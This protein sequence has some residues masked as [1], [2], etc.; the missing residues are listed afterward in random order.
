MRL[1]LLE[2]L[3]KLGVDHMLEAYE[4]QPWLHYDED[5]GITASAEVR[6][7]PGREDLEAEIQFLYDDHEDIDETRPDEDE[8]GDADGDGAGGAMPMPEGPPVPKRVIR[9][10]RE[11]IM[12]MRALPAFD[13]MWEVK[14]LIV[15]TN[16]YVNAF[17]GWEEKGCEFFTSCAQSL[18]M[19]ELPD[20]NDIIEQTLNEQ[21]RWGGGRAGRVGRKSPKIKP[22]ALLGMKQGG[23]M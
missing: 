10:G 17:H 7:G 12:I 5:E 11:M 4:T 20:I 19:G 21:D 9:S 8:Q 22:G 23:G 14:K 6:M 2:L 18:Q 1:P 3:E 15:R 13:D 16:D